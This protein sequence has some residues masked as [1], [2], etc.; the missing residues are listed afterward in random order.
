M[1]ENTVYIYAIDANYQASQVQKEK[2]LLLLEII[3]PEAEHPPCVLEKANF[4]T[5]NNEKI[6]ERFALTSGFLS[7]S[8]K[9]WLIDASEPAED[10]DEDEY[11]ELDF[12]TKLR[13]EILKQFEDILGTKVA[14]AW[15]HED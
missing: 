15:V 6:I 14:V 4:T 7:G 1:N 12:G 10:A 3:V 13:P 5:E 8:N 11:D 9:Y 2:A